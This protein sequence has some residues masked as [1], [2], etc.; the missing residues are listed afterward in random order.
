[1]HISHS[2]IILSRTSTDKHE[3]SKRIG[4]QA[5]AVGQIMTS[6]LHAKIFRLVIAEDDF[7][8][9]YLSYDLFIYFLLLLLRLRSFRI[10][11]YPLGKLVASE[12]KKRRKK[13]GEKGW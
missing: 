8:R 7:V 10:V 5:I 1:M 6:S 3:T 13:E 11:S 9:A 12:T 2:E 4:H